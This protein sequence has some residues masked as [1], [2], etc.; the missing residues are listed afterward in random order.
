MLR[1]IKLTLSSLVPILNFPQLS[2]QEIV[3]IVRNGIKELPESDMTSEKVPN[4]FGTCTQKQIANMTEENHENMSTNLTG[5]NTQSDIESVLNFTDTEIGTTI[6]NIDSTGPTPVINS[7]ASLIET[8]G[9]N[10][11]CPNESEN[12]EKEIDGNT[13]QKN[14]SQVAL[15][16]HALKTKRVELVASMFA[17]IVQGNSGKTYSVQLSPKERCNCPSTTTCWHIIAAKMSCGMKENNTK[18]TLNLSQLKR[19]SRTWLD[20]KSGRKHLRPNDV[21]DI[22]ITAAPD[23][24][25]SSMIS[26]KKSCVEGNI[27]QI[28]T[29]LSIPQY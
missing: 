7:M 29:D 25:L 26:I 22:E 12:G 13:L 21:D 28:A 15:A 9:T 2:L 3:D 17:F 24:K 19:N 6:D 8:K 20:K 27:P 1:V 16:R 11:Q 5:E 23:S 10:S 4:T 14:L 18:C